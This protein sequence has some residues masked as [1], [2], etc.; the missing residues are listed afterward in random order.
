MSVRRRTTGEWR[1]NPAVVF[2]HAGE[3]YLVGTY[4]HP[5]WSVGP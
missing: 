5:E 2:D 3:R 1:T 4:G